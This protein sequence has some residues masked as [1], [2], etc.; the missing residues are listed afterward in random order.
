MADTCRGREASTVRDDA[1]TH[2]AAAFGAKRFQQCSNS[3]D[4]CCGELAVAVR[5]WMPHLWVC[6]YVPSLLACGV[7]EIFLYVEST[8]LLSPRTFPALEVVCAN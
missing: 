8:G 3:V 1:N 6:M 7:R 5:L 2:A 4:G